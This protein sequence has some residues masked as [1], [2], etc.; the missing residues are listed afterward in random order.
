M[1]ETDNEY[2]I[3]FYAKQETGED[4]KLDLSMQYV[5]DDESTHYDGI[6]TFDLS[7]S[8]WTK[9]EATMTVPEHTGTI[10]IYWQSVYN[11]NNDMDF[12]LDEVTMTGVAKTADE[13]SGLPDLSTGLVKGKSAIRL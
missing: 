1:V 6:K 11:S 9:C 5:G 7:D 12:Y 10:L 2:A 13:N 4:Q 3:S 8:T